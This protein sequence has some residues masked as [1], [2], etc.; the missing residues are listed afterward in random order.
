M[1][2]RWLPLLLTMFACGAQ[3]A[4]FDDEEARARIEALRHQA[5]VSQKAVDERIAKIEAEVRDRRALIDLAGQIDALKADLARMRGQIEVLLNQAETA[6]KRQKDL[7]LDIDTRLRKLELAKEAADK[8]A[9]EAAPVA[10]E[11]TKAYEAALNQFKLGNYPLAIAA[12]QGLLV[13]YP[14][15]KLAPNAQYW[16]GMAHAAQRDYK[17]AI[18]AQQ[19]VLVAWP[20]DA[21]A[22]DAMLN[23]GAS[24]EAL[25]DRRGAQKTFEGL[26]DLYPASQAA[27]TAKQRLQ[28]R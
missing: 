3:A 22:P 27:A 11:E 5:A 1:R 16:T 17:N 28:K 26:L 19:K 10:A 21:K 8:P 6:D 14:N 24:Q 18:A 4:M 9:A 15:S 12:L 2:L 23:I 7:Y 20:N 25:G 13:I